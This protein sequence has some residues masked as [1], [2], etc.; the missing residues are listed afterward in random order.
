MKTVVIF[1]HWFWV[2]KDAYGLFTQLS[3][4]LQDIWIET[5]M[6]DYSSYNEGTKELLTTP[7]S[8][9][10]KVL[11][12]II[13]K[14]HEEYLDAKLIIIWH[15]QWCIIPTLC[16][17][18]H[19]SGIV[20]LAPFFHTDMQDILARYT[21]NIS[22]EV[23]FTWISKR[24]RSDGSITIIPPEYRKERF[25]SNIIEQYNTLA[26]IKETYII[27]G[28]Q[29]QVMK[30]TEQHRIKNSYIINIDSDH[31]FS[32]QYRSWLISIIT[33]IFKSFLN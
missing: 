21:K 17:L 9:Q 32:K 1:S 18:S 19:I 25:A 24:Y 23:N 27:Y 28:L 3:K 2:R 12:N 31:D 14:T 7:F 22:S 29:D 10:A 15:S 26:L 16:D 8:E 5:I 11:Q 30:F 6:F 4:I 20:M 33:H 13:N